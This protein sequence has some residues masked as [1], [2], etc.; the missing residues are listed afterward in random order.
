MDNLTRNFDT[1]FT[2]R[3]KRVTLNGGFT[4][5]RDE[6]DDKLIAEFLEKNSVTKC[7]PTGLTG[8]EA[9]RATNELVAKQRRAWRKTK[10]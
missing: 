10:K 5:P 3:A 2:D 9:C 6:E 7:P 8:N 4:K 1:T